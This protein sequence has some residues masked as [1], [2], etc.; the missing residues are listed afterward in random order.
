VT[1]AA[2]TTIL[3]VDDDLQDRGLLVNLLEL[4]GYGVAD[5]GS[6]AEARAALQAQTFTLAICDLQLPGEAH[7]N[8]ADDI[9]A[10]HPDTALLIVSG[11]ADRATADRFTAAGTYGYLIKPFAIDQFLITVAN[12]L[13]RHELE[14]ERATYERGLE[15]IVSVRTAELRRSRVETVRRLAAAVESRDGE[16]GL[17]SER[18]GQFG[19]VIARGL[20]LEAEFCELI[21]VALPLHDIGKIAVPDSILHKPGPLSPSERRTMETH[22]TVGHDL[23]AGSGEQ[24][25][26]LAALIAW[27]HHER[28]DGGGYPRGLEGR[29]IPVPGR[30]G[31]VADC[32][33]ALTTDRPYRAARPLEQALAILAEAR[34]T[35]LDGDMVEALTA[36]F[37]VG[38]AA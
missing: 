27:T 19:W 25:L 23:L 31:A 38:S 32:L 12:A 8:L 24:L 3:V 33:D 22:T 15:E 37:A 9:R 6:A 1:R 18:T 10:D 7:G 2:S 30:I 14:H 4:E 36:S 16:T 34:G 35:Q 20:G 11:N 5:F 17:H 21:R 13:R 28:V 26:E 29:A